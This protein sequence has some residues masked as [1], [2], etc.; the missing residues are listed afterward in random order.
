MFMA[1][2]KRAWDA[3][4]KGEGKY[5]ESSLTDDAQIIG[6]SGNMNKAAIVAMINTK[7][8]TIKSYNLSNFKVT[9]LDSNTAIATY[10]AA[11]DGTCGGMALPAKVYGTSIYVKRKGKWQGVLHQETAAMAMK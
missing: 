10:E 3:F 6:D 11:E 9:M 8:C 5:F 2:E 1:M 7:P 4:G